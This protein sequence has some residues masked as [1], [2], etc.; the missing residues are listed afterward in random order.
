MMAKAAIK[1]AAVPIGKR[2][3]SLPELDEEF[4]T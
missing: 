2:Y 1:R 4:I 3:S